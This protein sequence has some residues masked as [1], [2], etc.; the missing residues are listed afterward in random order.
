MYILGSMR[1]G[2]WPDKR[3]LKARLFQWRPPARGCKSEVQNLN[4]LTT[5]PIPKLQEYLFKDQ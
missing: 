5:S 1:I 4:K 2:I 3:V